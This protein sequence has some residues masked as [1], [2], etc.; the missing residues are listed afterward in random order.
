MMLTELNAG[1]IDSGKFKDINI[2]VKL[3][4]VV[5]KCCYTCV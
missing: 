2:Q 5:A 1:S 4:C 3:L